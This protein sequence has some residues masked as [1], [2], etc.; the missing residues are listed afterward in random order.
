MYDIY[1]LRSHLY[2]VTYNRICLYINVYITIY[3]INKGKNRVKFT[4]A[5]L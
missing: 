5:D 3:S 4:Y 2:I 1:I